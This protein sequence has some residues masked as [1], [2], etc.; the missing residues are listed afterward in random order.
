MTFNFKV[1]LIDPNPI[2]QESFR[3]L[4]GVIHI[5]DFNEKLY[6]KDYFLSFDLIVIDLFYYG[7]QGFNLI[8]QIILNDLPIKLIIYSNIHAT[9]WINYFNKLGILVLTKTYLIED[10]VLIFNNF[11]SK[12]TNTQYRGKKVI[13]FTLRELE[14]IQEILKGKSV[15]QIAN[16]LYVSRNTIDFHRKNIFNKMEVN[17]V[18]M[19]IIRLNNLGWTISEKYYTNV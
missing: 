10:L 3:L 5:I 1:L 7:L 15:K 4:R 17:S 11:C 16:D 14:V 12:K 13:R 6:H 19:L 8:N 2:I 18:E 9:Y